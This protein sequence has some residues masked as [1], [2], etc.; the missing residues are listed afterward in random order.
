MISAFGS[1]WRVM[2]ASS[3]STM[4][5]YSALRAYT[6]STPM[7]SNKAAVRGASGS[8]GKS[9]RVGAVLMALNR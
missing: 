9:M 2:Y 4:R 8:A 5:T 6:P 7:G 1:R 3:R